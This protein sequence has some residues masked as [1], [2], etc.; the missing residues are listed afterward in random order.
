MKK[1]NYLD[2]GFLI[3]EN[4][5]SPMHVGG[6]SLYTLPEGVNE[7]EFLHGLAEMLRT[8]D[9]FQ[10]P[11]GEKLKTGVLGVVGP[12]YWEKDKAVDIDYHIRHS[13]LPK[14]GRYRELFRLVSRL[15]ST[16][17]DR[18]R[19][20]WEMHLIEGLQNRQFAVYTKTHHAA[21]D[22]ATSIHLTRSM[23]SSN[24]D[25][26][27]IDSPL[28]LAAGERYR[29]AMRRQ[30]PDSFTGQ[31]IRNVADVVKATFDSGTEIA[32]ALRRTVNA[33]RGKEEGLMLPFLK[34]PRSS[35][36]TSIAGA[37]R[38]VAQTWPFARIRA[39]GKVFDGTF[40]DAVMAMCAGGLRL[41]MQ[42]YAEL[43]EQSLKAMVPVSL[44]RPGDMDSTNAVG[45]IGVDLATTEADPAR[46]FEIIRNS[47]R[48][49]KEF[50]FQMS[51]NEAQLFSVLL[52]VPGMLL[53]PLGLASKFPP[54]NTVISNVP[55][56]LEPMY[57]NGAR[58]DGSYPASIVTDGVALNITMVTYDKNVDFGIM[59]CRRS[60]PHIQR[61]ID[62]IEQALVDLE[63]A[64]G[65]ATTSFETTVT[66]RKKP[67]V[68]KKPAAKKKVTAKKA[69]P[70]RKSTTKQ[71]DRQNLTRS[72]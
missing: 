7:Q 59:A 42:N 3:S 45:S 10:P 49:G 55:G 71:V 8:V 68:R 63:N 12:M 6:V 16:L 54:Y 34:V 56:I 28:S 48:A 25:E 60:L 17:L 37:R 33:W 27:I 31:E 11:Y 14:P 67:V 19:P 69:T 26:R 36:N 15:H 53:V 47:A 18:S 35:I 38:F 4:R 22:G 43:P 65:I 9:S 40:N 5:E 64:A 1:L 23:L 58:M 2:A 30:F 44:R 66:P 70:K 51:S 41:Y 24:P 72:V 39:V 21:V 13:A 46:R 29:A 62:Y 52:Q 50:F 32:G 20:L 61:L 57:W